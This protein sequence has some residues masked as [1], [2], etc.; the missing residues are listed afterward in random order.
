MLR[1]S[2][3][4]VKFVDDINIVKYRYGK[5]NRIFVKLSVYDL[6]VLCDRVFNKVKLNFMF[7]KFS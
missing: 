6:R 2:K 4:V 7:V 3:V 5:D 1:N